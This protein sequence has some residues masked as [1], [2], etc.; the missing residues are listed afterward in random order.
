M[1]MEAITI[2]ELAK[3]LQKQIQA[4]NGD[5]KILLSSDDEGNEY[6]EMFFMITSVES[7]GLKE[8]QIPVSIDEAVEN[9]VIL[10]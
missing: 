3:A 5:K 4:G 10:G 6:H 1:I 9:Y 2:N 8:Y 7:V